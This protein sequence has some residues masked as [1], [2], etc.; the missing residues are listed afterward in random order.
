MG[1]RASKIGKNSINSV[2]D[3]LFGDAVSELT[4]FA[5]KH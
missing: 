1:V 3:L 2:T 5:G 4:S